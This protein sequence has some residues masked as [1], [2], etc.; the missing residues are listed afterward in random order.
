LK[1][2]TYDQYRNI[3][4]DSAQSL[5]KDAGGNFQVQFIHPGLF[6]VTP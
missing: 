1:Q 5:W 3:R 6:T 2:L 4:F